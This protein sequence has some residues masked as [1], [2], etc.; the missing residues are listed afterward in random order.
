[1]TQTVG[2]QNLNQAQKNLFE[3]NISKKIFGENGD[4]LD[5]EIIK[6]WARNVPITSVN[7]DTTKVST[8]I[9]DIPFPTGGKEQFGDFT[10]TF[11]LN[12]NFDPYITLRSWL[13]RNNPYKVKKTKPVP[14]NPNRQL[15]IKDWIAKGQTEGF[16][17]KESEW[18]HMDYRDITISLKNLNN[19]ES[20]YVK[21][22]DAFPVSISSIDLTNESTD[23][24]TF[25]VTFKALYMDIIGEGGNSLIIC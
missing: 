23:I 11:A 5:T 6:L 22:V 24:I 13:E 3:V 21:Y 9:N 16:R 8:N 15:S 14:F 1:M 12:E 4:L 25:T 7:T 18:E 10:I 2:H 17:T 19:I 20:C